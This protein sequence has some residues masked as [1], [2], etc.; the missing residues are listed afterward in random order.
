M[1]LH[2]SRRR[3]GTAQGRSL[4][5]Q[6]DRSARRRRHLLQE[7]RSR[8]RFL[9]HTAQGRWR[10]GRDPRTHLG[11]QRCRLAGRIRQ[12]WRCQH[13]HH[14]LEPQLRRTHPR[15]HR[16][17]QVQH[18][19]LPVGRQGQHCRPLCQIHRSRAGH[20]ES[21]GVQHRFIR[22]PDPYGHGQRGRRR[23]VARRR[24]QRQRR[25][26]G[27]RIQHSCRRSAGLL[28]RQRTALLQDGI[29]LHHRQRR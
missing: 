13:R 16:E 3:G 1:H 22:R 12:A 7:V 5:L 17:E 19:L 21:M 9:R 11:L 15:V 27:S 4:H 28:H 25:C 23:A 26:Q 2:R 10:R 20:P 18:H 14:E 8:R 29:H 24:L 6:R